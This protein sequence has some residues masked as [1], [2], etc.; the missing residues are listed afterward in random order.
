[1]HVAE[2][3]VLSLTPHGFHR[4]AYRE[5]GDPG[6]DRVVLC[7]HGLTRLGRDFDILAA[8]LA[9]RY[10]VACPDLPGRGRSH[11]LA[12]PSDYNPVVYAADMAILI[13][14]LGVDEI[15][16]VGTSLGG[17]VGMILA[18]LPNSPIRKL[19]LN[20]IGAFIA[21]SA[22]ERIS[23]YVGR[24]PLFADLKEAEAYLRQ[25]HSTFGPLTDAQ[26]E[27]LTRTS[28]QH[29]PGSDGWRLYYDPELAEPFRKGFGSDDDRW[30]L[31][32]KITCPVLI[33]RGEQSDILLHETAEEML[34]RGP[35]AELIEFPGIGHAPMLMD[36]IQIAAVREWLLR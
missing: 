35:T 5:W 8:A 14:R 13:A 33:L 2:K 23:D 12:V 20:D 19:V 3:S 24:N 7:L 9:D 32:E 1:M 10:R 27:H 11:W 34:V 18:A 4:V 26:W 25:I 30:A 6:N 15:D 16:W 29:D 22:L 21:K 17:I 28:V 36:P 31:W